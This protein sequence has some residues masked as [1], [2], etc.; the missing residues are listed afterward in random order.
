LATFKRAL[1]EVLP[2]LQRRARF[3]CGSAADAE[4]AVQ[5]TCERALR[6]WRQWS[7]A[8]DLEHWLIKILIN[9]SRDERRDRRMRSIC[10]ARL[11]PMYQDEGKDTEMETC[12]EQMRAQIALLPPAQRDAL[13]LVVAEGLSYKDAARILGVP[14]GT[15]MS[16]LARARRALIE[17]VSADDG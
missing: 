14:V 17:S 6:H 15:V 4:D 13:M 12:I 9:A 1:V 7:G 2:R 8:G 5:L 11:M 16:R 10:A 3:Y